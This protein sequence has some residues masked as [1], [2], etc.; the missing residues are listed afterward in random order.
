MRGVVLG[1]L[2]W[3]CCIRGVVLEVLYWGVV[4]EVSH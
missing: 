3:R 2:Y 4:L 1:A